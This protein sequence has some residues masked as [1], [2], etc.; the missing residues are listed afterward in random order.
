MMTIRGSHRELIGLPSRFSARP[1]R[2]SAAFLLMGFLLLCA[3]FCVSGCSSGG[4]TD[5][6]AE[7][8]EGYVRQ[9]VEEYG[10][11]ED[12]ISYE[13]NGEGETVFITF[14]PEAV[15][16]RDIVGYEDALAQ[17]EAQVLAEQ[18]N[19]AVFILGYTTD[20]RLVSAVVGQPPNYSELD[21]ETRD[22]LISQFVNLQTEYAEFA[23]SHSD[24]WFS[25]YEANAE[26]SL[27]GIEDVI[28]TFDE[29][30]NAYAVAYYWA[31]GYCPSS[32]EQ[33]EVS[34]WQYTADYISRSTA[35]NV[36]M[37][38]GT[39]ADGLQ[40]TFAASYADN[41]LY[42]VRPSEYTNP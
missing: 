3:F 29:S 32:D 31:D 18:L 34:W 38:H 11:S 7:I 8:L 30:I 39:G 35:S 33:D 4:A 28:I 24:E 16:S 17:D 15:F 36:L 13:D 22:E 27:E 1:I 25:E 42:G 10:W 2:S 26:Q 41:I 20:D 9:Q 21:E 23:R 5:P 12:E 37:M 40:L 14:T 19:S 6:R